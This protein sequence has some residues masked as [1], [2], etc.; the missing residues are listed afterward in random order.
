M[1]VLPDIMGMQVEQGVEPY[2]GAVSAVSKEVV[3]SVAKE[4]VHK[5]VPDSLSG[6]TTGAPR[7]EGVAGGV[8]SGLGLGFAYSLIVSSLHL[9]VLLSDLHPEFL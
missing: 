5:D 2:G 7:V 3:I 8:G 4:A 6:G 9:V 1:A